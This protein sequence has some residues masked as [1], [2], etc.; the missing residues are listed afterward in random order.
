MYSL[1]ALQVLLVLNSTTPGHLSWIMPLQLQLALTL[2]VTITLRYVRP[3]KVP[4]RQSSNIAPFRCPFQE[5]FVC[6]QRG[7]DCNTTNVMRGIMINYAGEYYE[8]GKYCNAGMHEAGAVPTP[9]LRNEATLPLTCVSVQDWVKSFGCPFQELAFVCV[10]TF[11]GLSM[12]VCLQ[13]WTKNQVS[14][15]TDHVTHC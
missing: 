5:L 3:V 14:T 8:Y 13:N 15:V 4:T 6:Y 7:V 12:S 2:A 1:R 10:H 9:V 11:P